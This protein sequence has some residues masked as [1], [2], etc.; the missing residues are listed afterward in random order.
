MRSWFAVPLVVLASSSIASAEPTFK[1]EAIFPAEPKHNHASCVIELAH[2]DLLAAWYSGS[3]ER[4]ADDV[5]IQG[6]WL[7]A[8]GD[9]W[10]PRF[11]MADT[12]GYPDCNPALRRPGSHHLALLADHP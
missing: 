9:Q 11:T 7:K 3:G 4:T 12:P 2:G 1:S 8:G 10:G 6:A 5:Q